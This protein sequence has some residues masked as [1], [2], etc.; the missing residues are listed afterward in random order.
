MGKKIHLSSIT[1]RA[2][3]A[4]RQLRDISA[5]LEEI[6]ALEGSDVPG[7]KYLETRFFTDERNQLLDLAEMLEEELAAEATRYA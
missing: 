1:P 7:W 6:D 4:A 3:H 5:I 2:L